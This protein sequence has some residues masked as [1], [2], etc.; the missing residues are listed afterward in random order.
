MISKTWKFFLLL[1]LSLS[2]CFAFSESVSH[3][4]ALYEKGW[5]DI[6][7]KNYSSAI[8]KFDESYSLFPEDQQWMALDGKAWIDYFQGKYGVAKEQFLSIIAKY[9]QAYLSYKGL[10]YVEIKQ[11]SWDAAF[12]NLAHAFSLNAQ[13]PIS[14]Y[15]YV[16]NAFLGAK[17]FKD[18]HHFLALAQKIYPHSGEIQFYLAKAL[19]LEGKKDAAYTS[20]LNAAYYSPS[21]VSPLFDSLKGVNFQK[22]KPALLYMGWGLYVDGY[23]PAALFRFNQYLTFSPRDLNAL[24]G[25]GFCLVQLGQSDAAIPILESVIRHKESH[26]LLP[27]QTYYVTTQKQSIPVYTD[28]STMLAWALYNTGHYQ[29]AEK[30]FHEILNKQ[31]TWIN[32]RLGLAHT[33]KAMDNNQYQQEVKI[34]DKEAPGYASQLPAV[35]PY[36]LKQAQ[37]AY[38]Q[39]WQNVF[40]K[41]YTEALHDFD[42]AQKFFPED[43][44][45][46]AQD[47]KA[48]VAFYQENDA[49]AAS[50]FKSIIAKNP[51]A[52]LSQKGLAYILLKKKQ[53]AAAFQYLQASLTT[54]PLQGA[55]VYIYTASIFNHAKQFSYL[56]KIVD[57]GLQYYPNAGELLFYK[58]KLLWTK[59]QKNQAYPLLLKASYF[60]PVAINLEFNAETFPNIDFSK[61]TP[62][63]L[64]IGWGLYA[65]QYYQAALDRFNQYNHF[66]SHPKKLTLEDLNALRG[67]GYCYA[68]LQQYKL[69]EKKLS[70]VVKNPLSKQLPPV[71][72]YFYTTDKKSVL[73]PT[74]AQSM[75][76]WVKYYSNRHHTAEKHFNAVLKEHPDWVSARL[77]LAHVLHATNRKEAA[78]QHLAV[79][80]SSAAGYGQIYIPPKPFPL[81]LTL[82][83]TKTSYD[84]SNAVKSDAM[85]YQ[86]ALAYSPN[87]HVQLGGYHTYQYIRFR[88]SAKGSPAINQRLAYFVT[89]YSPRVNFAKG[90]LGLSTKGNYFIKSAYNEGAAN[91]RIIP[92]GG[93]AYKT[94]DELSVMEAGF[95]RGSYSDVIKTKVYQWNLSLK[96]FRFA[97]WALGLITYYEKVST[98]P[99]QEKYFAAAP[100][101]TYTIT[102]KN[103]IGFSALIGNRKQAYDLTLNKVYDVRD[104][105]IGGGG[106]TYTHHFSK[107]VSLF[108][109]VSGE[110]F[111][112]AS[113]S[114]HYWG[115]YFTLGLTI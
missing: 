1:F 105:E 51:H 6:G 20:L 36:A 70:R 80:N 71:T 43:Q 88:P 17:R 65:A 22:I 98:T 101:L 54:A 58:A 8:K 81:T 16:C 100:N 67:Q 11:D 24:R 15:A 87:S 32:A 86:T 45:W 73:V 59:G 74:N 114:L 93:I 37:A 28:A 85:T 55:E 89:L 2:P 115:Y 95:S 23:Y 69:A 68:G 12:M 10:G 19:W 109:D 76:G 62:A 102:P 33:L 104:R 83:G 50:Q 29:R 63:L 79:I 113:N 112:L 21:I 41:K 94:D 57:K 66:I 44:Q 49:S 64:N 78:Q 53:Y 5:V 60:A 31:P 111:L 97:P 35:T 106:I 30:L 75:L 108:G 14:E 52:Y 84:G 47:G 110:E 96:T 26:T 39:G 90:Y 18:A 82:Q 38:A 7:A 56:Q 91:H 4:M 13:Q 48:W 72:S 9:P 34:I 61:L 27:V 77:G 25:K 103:D 92:Y 40:A 46:T 99:K 107:N 42:R 3:G